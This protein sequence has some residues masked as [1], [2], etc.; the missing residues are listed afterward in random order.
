MNSEPEPIDPPLSVGALTQRIKQVL[1]GSFNDLWVRGEISNLRQQ[2]SGHLYFTLKDRE[3]QLS[4]VMFRPDAVRSRLRLEEGMAVLAHGRVSVYA[5]RGNYQLIVRLLRREGE[6]ELRQRFEQLKQRLAAEGLFDPGRKRPLPS[7]PSR[8]VVIT[9]PSG[10]ALRDFLSILRRRNWRGCVRILPVR[11]QGRESAPEIVS[12][13]EQA[14]REALGELVVLTRGGGSLEDLWPFN[15]EI[16][17]RAIASS[18][19]PV[20]SAVGHE[21]D[22]TLSD[23]AADL[24]AETPSAAAEILSSPLLAFSESVTRARRQLKQGIRTRLHREQLRTDALRQ[25]LARNTPRHR[26][27]HAW[28]RLDD[29]AARRTRIWTSAHT[30]AREKLAAT[31]YRLG[32]LDPQHRIRLARENLRQLALRLRQASPEA[33]LQRGFAMIQDADGR[34]IQNRRAAEGTTAIV[35][36]WADGSLPF[37][38]QPPTPRQG[39]LEFPE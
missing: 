20:I 27:E 9:S 3:A 11:V 2:S 30:D 33:V 19:L 38:S 18:R 21:I 17:A 28:L 8:L 31:R 39:Q 36:R 32:S 1:E 10:A 25:R 14:N 24:R 15:E 29:L 34:V 16:V 23:F 22:F 26:L 37:Q 13:L 6:G 4:A 35:V 5:P 12:M 7:L